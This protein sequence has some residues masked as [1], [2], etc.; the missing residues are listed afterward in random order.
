MTQVE[1]SG[2]LMEEEFGLSHDFV[3]HSMNPKSSEPK[4]TRVSE[5]QSDFI[6]FEDEF[7]LVK[8]AIPSFST[9]LQKGQECK[10]EIIES[11]QIFGGKE[12]KWRVLN[13]LEVI[14]TLIPKSLDLQTIE[15]NIKISSPAF[16]FSINPSSRMSKYVSI[17]NNSTES[18]KLLKCY[19]NPPE[20]ENIKLVKGS[21]EGG[22]ILY[23]LKPK[24][25]RG[26]QLHIQIFPQLIGNFEAEV[27]ADFQTSNNE[28]FTKSHTIHIKVVQELNLINGPKL[29]NTIRFTDIRFKDY[30]IPETLRELDFT[31]KK[32]ILEKLKEKFPVL[33][34]EVAPSNYVER[35]SLAIYLDEIAME[36][37]F[38]EYHLPRAR[39]EDHDKYLKLEVSDVAEK[40]PSII[41]GDAVEATD[42]FCDEKDQTVYK[43]YIFK[44][45]NDAVLIK[46]HEDFH[47]THRGK[48]YTVN[49]CFSRSNFRQQH[50]AIET[51]VRKLGFDFL[52]PRE[53]V[54]R[55][56]SV[57]VE[58]KNEKLVLF[59]QKE[60]PWFE[61]KLNKYQKDAIVNAMRGEC[62][63]MPYM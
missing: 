36:M 4:Y 52:F 16:T 26:F 62:R 5:V 54:P 1:I 15:K 46:F 42:P 58:L 35:M 44:V 48:V 57:Y 51:V 55:N 49:F 33:K 9:E 50:H 11:Y 41:I 63:P 21:N 23:H 25:K 40:R 53:I 24:D 22:K 31:R 2:E 7:L 12:F 8:S 19:F 20:P 39:F 3:P 6:V 28:N 32:E 27:F 18:V 60:L 56:L 43:G 34:E 30:W 13:V 45:E 47:Q 14:K 10:I 59:G 38:K 37:A 61:R 29:R 17:V